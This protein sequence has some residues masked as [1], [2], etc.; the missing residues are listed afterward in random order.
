MQAAPIKLLIT[1]GN[2]EE[3]D[4]RV[5]EVLHGVSTDHV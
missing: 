3:V 4:E 2:L 1:I 5:L